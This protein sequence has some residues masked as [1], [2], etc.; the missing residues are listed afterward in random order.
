MTPADVRR[1]AAELIREEG[2]TQG[3]YGWEH[4][5]RGTKRCASI[6]LVDAAAELIPRDEQLARHPVLQRAK[7]QVLAEIGPEY[8]VIPEWND[9]PERT[10]DEV[11]AVLDPES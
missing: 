7:A 6:A 8:I 1:R 5:V 3:G 2:W 10:A 4:D 9:M 11:V